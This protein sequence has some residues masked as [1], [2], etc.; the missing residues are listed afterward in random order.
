M[1]GKNA[2]GNYAN[3]SRIRHQET[4]DILFII[5]T[6]HGFQIAVKKCVSLLLL[7]DDSCALKSEMRLSLSHHSTHEIGSS[8][9][10]TVRQKQWPIVRMHHVK[11]NQEAIILFRQASTGLFII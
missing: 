2:V 11:E 5:F 10:L 7:N 4:D 3:K 1:R 6:P 9:V 8:S